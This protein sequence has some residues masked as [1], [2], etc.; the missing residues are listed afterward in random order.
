MAPMRVV[1]V[2]PASGDYQCALA[3][4]GT[5]KATY[6]NFSVADKELKQLL[7]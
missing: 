5:R 7:E 2:D 3:Q 4:Q 6:R 1:G